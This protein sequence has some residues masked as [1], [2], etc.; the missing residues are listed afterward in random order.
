MSGE[1]ILRHPVYWNSICGVD[2]HAA[3]LKVYHT[4][5]VRNVSTLQKRP[6]RY[7]EHTHA[8]RQHNYLSNVL[9]LLLVYLL[10]W[11]K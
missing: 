9:Y 5:A 8:N 11:Q 10:D 7:S 3:D 2:E 4:S 1:N 6:L